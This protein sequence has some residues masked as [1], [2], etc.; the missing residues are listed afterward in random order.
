M[1]QAKGLT[2]G[3]GGNISLMCDDGVLIT[4]SGKSFE[5]L[6][7]SDF[8]LLREDGSYLSCNGLVPSKEWR[9]HLMCYKKNTV[10]AVV[11]LHST[12]SVI[13]AC[14][15]NINKEC[16]IPIYTPGYGMRVGRLPLIPYATP[17]SQELST[18]VY[19]ALKS[20]KAVLLQNHGYIVTDSSLE[21]A[22]N[23]AEEIEEEAKLH[24]FLRGQGITLTGVQQQQLGITDPII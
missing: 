13:L 3:S 12:F 20:H 19:S 15:N 18:M 1:I 24:V 8:V 16:A 6:S 23:T 21:S 9:M 4:P 22:I 5:S 14:S 7:A 2:C 17:G 11:H 10:R